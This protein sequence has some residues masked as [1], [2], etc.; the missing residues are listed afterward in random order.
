M[1]WGFVAAAAVGAVGSVVGA[2][3]QASASENATNTQEQMFNQQNQNLAPYRTTGSQANT[4]LGYLEGVGP[5]TGGSSALGGYGSLNQPFN[6]S[7]WKSLSPSYGFQLQQGAQGTLN[8][9]SSAQ[10]AESGAALSSLQSYNQNF[11]NSSFNNAFNMYQTQ[12]GNIFNRLSGLAQ[13]G[14]AASSNQASGGSNY[15]NSISQSMTNTG[16]AIGAGIAGAGNSFSQ[17]GLLGA[18]YNGQQGS[19]D[20]NPALN[21][22]GSINSTYAPSEG[23]I[24]G[25]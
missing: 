6:T 21:Y 25:Y 5:K 3:E 24:A 13:T 20:Q 9:S 22:D 15:A 7:D 19:G 14:E 18:L 1:P 11:A 10:G 23:L 17:A 12:Q 4:E 16:T 8:Q 2:G